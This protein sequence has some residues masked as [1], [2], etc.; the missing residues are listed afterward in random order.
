VVPASTWIIECAENTL[1][2]L[3]DASAALVVTDWEE[4][5]EL[6]AEF[7]TMETPVVV[8]GRHPI[9]RRREHFRGLT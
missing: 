6:D 2:T 4:I 1:R 8:D 5:T 7:D 3:H 9:E